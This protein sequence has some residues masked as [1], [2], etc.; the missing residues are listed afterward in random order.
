MPLLPGQGEPVPE[1][2][3]AK[4]CTCKSRLTYSHHVE[5]YL[6]LHSDPFIIQRQVKGAVNGAAVC[7]YVV[8]CD[9]VNVNGRCLH[10]TVWCAMPLDTVTEVF[11][12]DISPGMVVMENL[13]QQ[14]T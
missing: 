12:E 6:L 13:R 4:V 14:R 8:V 7:P 3:S 1:K 10:I 11:V 5:F 9:I 2:H